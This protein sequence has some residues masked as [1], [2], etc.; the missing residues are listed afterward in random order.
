MALPKSTQIIT[1]KFEQKN[2][3]LEHKDVKI[4]FKP[5]KDKS[6]SDDVWLTVEQGVSRQIFVNAECFRYLFVDHEGKVDVT[7]EAEDILGY[8]DRNFIGLGLDFWLDRLEPVIAQF[9]STYKGD[10][11]EKFWSIALF[12]VPYLSGLPTPSWNGW[13][14]FFGARQDKVNEEYVVS[15]VIGWNI[16]DIDNKCCPLNK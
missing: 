3:H 12:D 1:N 15:P 8:F 7:V 13:I 16:V 10:V 6:S 11:D 14:G 4:H 2:V 5:W 9:V